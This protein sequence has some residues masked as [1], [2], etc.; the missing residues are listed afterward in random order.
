MDDLLSEGRRTEAGCSTAA[1]TL[2]KNILRGSCLIRLGSRGASV[3]M[4]TALCYPRVI[5]KF[6]LGV[7]ENVVSLTLFI[8]TSTTGV[9]C[10][11]ALRLSSPRIDVVASR[12]DVLFVR[13][14]SLLFP[15]G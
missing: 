1:G 15:D 10:R 6:P 3:E 9:Q 11:E 13:E 7:N 8:F 5:K 2:A 4:E 14:A 12:P